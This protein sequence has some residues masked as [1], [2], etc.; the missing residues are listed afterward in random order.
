VRVPSLDVPDAAV[1]PFLS[2]YKGSYNPSG[3]VRVCQSQQLRALKPLT[4]CRSGLSA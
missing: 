1:R 4:D 2:S 3:S